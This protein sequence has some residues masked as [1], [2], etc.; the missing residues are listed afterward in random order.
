MEIYTIGF[1][2][3]SAA[4]F[5]GLLSKA[6]IR[7]LLDVRLNNT[8]QLAGFAK[9][10]D[11]EFFLR[12]LRGIEYRHEPLLAPSQEMLDDFKKKKGAWSDYELAYR[13]LLEQRQADQALSRSL[14]EIPTVMLC[15]EASAD[16]C[17]RRLAAAYLQEKW[18]NIRV[19]HL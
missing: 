10:E 19:I 6:G 12:E 5:F 16:Q 3:K 17:H 8:S 9:R 14:F 11:L 13:A 4:E 15:S 2:K 7:R 18:G 1:T